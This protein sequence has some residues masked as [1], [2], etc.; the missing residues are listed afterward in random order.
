MSAEQCQVSRRNDR[1]KN[2]K[3]F[4]G[5][6]DFY[7]CR[8][9]ILVNLS[10]KPFGW[11]D[12]FSSFC[13]VFFHFFPEFS[14]WRG[15]WGVFRV[16]FGVQR[17]VVLYIYIYWGGGVYDRKPRWC[18]SRPKGCRL[19]LKHLAAGESKGVRTPAPNQGGEQWRRL[20]ADCFSL[21]I[22]SQ[23]K[24]NKKRR[25]RADYRW[26][27][28]FSWCLCVASYSCAFVVIVP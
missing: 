18:A 12:F 14:F 19:A 27:A 17:G 15:I 7:H 20:P 2:Q 10:G 16:Y 23:G 4:G 22:N 9:Q 25:R 5:I 13:L 8:L 6:G 21:V 11:N 24:K 1:L 26:L 3:N 28:V